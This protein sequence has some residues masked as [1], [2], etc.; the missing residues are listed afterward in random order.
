MLLLRFPIHSLL[1]GFRFKIDGVVYRVQSRRRWRGKM[2]G[3]GW[4]W[5][6]AVKSRKEPK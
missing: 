3:K 5:A 6:K 1:S 4:Y 2:L